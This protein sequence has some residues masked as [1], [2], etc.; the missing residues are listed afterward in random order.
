[1]FNIKFSSNRYNKH[2]KNRI[3]IWI[4][5]NI[6]ELLT[7]FPIGYSTISVVSHIPVI[8]TMEPNF[9]LRIVSACFGCT[10]SCK[11]Y[12]D[13]RFWD[14][15]IGRSSHKP[16][17][18]S[19]AC[20]DWK[21]ICKPKLLRNLQSKGPLPGISV[22]S[23]G[24]NPLSWGTTKSSTIPRGLKTTEMNESI[25]QHVTTYQDPF[26]VG[27]PE[28][29]RQAEGEP[30]ARSNDAAHATHQKPSEHHEFH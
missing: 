26:S 25:I 9:T 23:F 14:A 12:D 11:N 19:F 15:K 4:S 8:S 5:L 7:T 10:V 29:Q 13:T 6:I 27:I 22:Y 20:Q 17:F 21:K 30:L 2:S 24:F 3:S 16:K 28:V 1:M 18:F